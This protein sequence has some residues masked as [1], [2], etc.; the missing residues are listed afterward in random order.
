MGDNRD[1]VG[2][3]HKWQSESESGS[4]ES[5]YSFHSFVTDI[6]GHAQCTVIINMSLIILAL[7]VIISSVLY[8]SIWRVV[9]G[10]SN[11]VAL[12]VTNRIST[13]CHAAMKAVKNPLPRRKS[14]QA[15]AS[16]YSSSSCPATWQ[17][18]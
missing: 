12:S 4:L 17:D 6:Y 11:V 2:F 14:H 15:P 7:S 5:W 13:Y 10:R 9:A 1:R 3:E 16:S 8:C 18:P